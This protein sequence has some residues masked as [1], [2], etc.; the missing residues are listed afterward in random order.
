M[1]GTPAW[2]ARLLPEPP[3]HRPHSPS[4]QYWPAGAHRGLSFQGP[5]NPATGGETGQPVTRAMSTTDVHHGYV[6]LA[7]LGG[8]P[9][10]V[11]ANDRELKENGC[12][13]RRTLLTVRRRGPRSWLGSPNS[14][15]WMEPPSRRRTPRFQ[16]RGGRAPRPRPLERHGLRRPGGASRLDPSGKGD[17]D[18]GLASY[19]LSRAHPVPALERGGELWG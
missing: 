17:V 8:I 1:P 7:H 12:V 15:T 14:R 13:G 6:R 3:G 11:R 18:P 2:D 16:G 4:Q 5:N 10:G 9:A 19:H